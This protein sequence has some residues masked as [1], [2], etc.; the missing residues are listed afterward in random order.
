[1]LVP[2][3]DPDASLSALLD[4]ALLDQTHLQ[5]SPRTRCSAPT[6]HSA[7]HSSPSTPQEPDASLSSLLDAALLDPEFLNY[8]PSATAAAA[9]YT[10]RLRR[11]DTPPWPA[12]LAL[13]TGWAG[14]VEQ[15]AELAAAVGGMQR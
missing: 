4:A 8:R 6:L 1:M 15:D 2:P 9:L 5:P 7:C 12:A 3:H 14:G 11:G 10:H 13:L